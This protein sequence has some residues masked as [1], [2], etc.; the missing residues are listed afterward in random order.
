[1]AKMADFCTLVDKT[2]NHPN[3]KTMPKSSWCEDFGIALTF[4]YGKEWIAVKACKKC[5]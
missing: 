4:L 1:M 3:K 5:T 2:P